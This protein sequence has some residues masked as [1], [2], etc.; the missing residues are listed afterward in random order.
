GVYGNIDGNEIRQI[1]PKHLMYKE[2][3]MTFWMTHIGGTYKR[4]CI[5][6]RK[7][8]ESQPPDVFICGH[9]HILKIKRDKKKNNML[10]LNPGAAGKYGNHQKR[11]CVRFEIDNGKL[12]NMDVIE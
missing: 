7:E 2:E 10:Y 1:F 8:M 6:I 9:S 11:T 5:P 12:K 4:Y 3:G